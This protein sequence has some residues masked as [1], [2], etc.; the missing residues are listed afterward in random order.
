[1][2]KIHLPISGLAVVAWL[3]AGPLHAQTTDSA[4]LPVGAT[5]RITLQKPLD[6]KKNKLGDP[7][8]AKS[9]ESVKANGHDVLP[10]G[11]K[12]I[13]RLTSVEAHSKEKPQAVLGVIFDRAILKD[14]REVPLRLAIQAVAPGQ[15]TDAPN[16]SLTPATAAGSAGGFGPVAGPITAGNGLDP[17]AGTPGRVG[18]PESPTADNMTSRGELTPSCRGVLRMEGMGLVPEDPTLGSL[19]VSRNRNIQLDIGTQMMLR[20]LEE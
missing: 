8:I 5:V 1:M 10:R 16:M 3:M 9:A 11:T 12:I 17:N 13:G 20:V 2:N 14:G 15:G 19:I 4:A 6:S 18:S 7:V